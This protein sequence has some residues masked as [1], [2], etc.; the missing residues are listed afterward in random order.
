MR[1]HRGEGDLPALRATSEEPKAKLQKTLE[2]SI[3]E[4]IN[5]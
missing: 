5:P 2:Q 4:K 3:G 1:V